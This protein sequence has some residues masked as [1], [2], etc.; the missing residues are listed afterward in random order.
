MWLSYQWNPKKPKF[1][2]VNLWLLVAVLVVVWCRIWCIG[3]EV[4]MFWRH[5]K[6]HEPE[7]LETFLARD[8]KREKKSSEIWYVAPESTDCNALGKKTLAQIGRVTPCRLIINVCH[9]QIEE[10][11]LYMTIIII[12]GCNKVA[13]KHLF[14]KNKIKDFEIILHHLINYSFNPQALIHQWI[15]F[16]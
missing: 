6:Q 7:E 15:G 16:C 2:L 12:L 10:A 14:E 3:C 11:G 8:E 1:Y 4:L 9:T 13:T 5:I